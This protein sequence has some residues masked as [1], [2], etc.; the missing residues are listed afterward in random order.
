MKTRPRPQENSMKKMNVPEKGSAGFWINVI[1]ISIF[2]FSFFSFLLIFFTMDLGLT[3]FFP[4]LLI[5]FS[6]TF[7][8][9]RWRYKSLMRMGKEE[10]EKCFIITSNSYIEKRRN[11][12][13]GDPY[14]PSSSS[15]WTIGPG[16]KI[17]E[18]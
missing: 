1:I 16:S 12:D 5:P 14:D 15:Y 11:I 6:A 17:G 10:Y 2:P 8:T 13:N 9:G 7:L 3:F 4:A 18:D